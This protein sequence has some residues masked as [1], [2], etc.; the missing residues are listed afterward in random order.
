MKTLNR[1]EAYKV[2]FAFLDRIYFEEGKNDDFKYDR[3]GYRC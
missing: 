1:L 2:M 3:G